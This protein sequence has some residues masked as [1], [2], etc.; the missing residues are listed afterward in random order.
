MTTPPK[1]TLL[2]IALQGENFVFRYNRLYINCLQTY[3]NQS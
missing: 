1:E 2:A 3:F